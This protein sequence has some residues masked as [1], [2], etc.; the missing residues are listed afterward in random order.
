[1]LKF[2]RSHSYSIKKNAGSTTKKSDSTFW[3]RSGL[4]DRPHASFARATKS[5]TSAASPA[6]P[7][8]FVPVSGVVIRLAA[9]A[10]ARVTSPNRTGA[11]VSKSKNNGATWATTEIMTTLFNA[12]E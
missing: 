8:S 10:M 9:D 7:A 5:G 2:S 11:D 6:M 4:N 1:M 3:R 12:A